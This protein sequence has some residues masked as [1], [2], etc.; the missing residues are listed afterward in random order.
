VASNSELQ[1]LIMSIV[2]L[3]LYPE[4]GHIIN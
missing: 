4:S 3:I 1:R 2:E